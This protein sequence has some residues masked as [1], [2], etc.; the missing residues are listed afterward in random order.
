MEL[1]HRLFP[2]IYLEPFEVELPSTVHSPFSEYSSILISL[3]VV[4]KFISPVPNIQLE[5]LN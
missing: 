2:K 3:D 1:F 5:T 4:C